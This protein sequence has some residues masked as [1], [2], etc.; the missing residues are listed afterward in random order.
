MK[1]IHE[2]RCVGHHSSRF[3]NT[4]RLVNS[5]LWISLDMFQNLIAH[6]EIERI[7]L[8]WQVCNPVFGI[9]N[10]NTFKITKAKDV[11]KWLRVT[12]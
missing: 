4:M 6:D 8:E 3:Q 11:A 7:I 5:G 1:L 2:A 12:D 9:I 10:F